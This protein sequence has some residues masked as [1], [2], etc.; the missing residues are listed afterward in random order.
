MLFLKSFWFASNILFSCIHI[1]LSRR[2]HRKNYRLV[3]RSSQHICE[4]TYLYTLWQR[5][6]SISHVLHREVQEVVKAA[7]T[8]QLWSFG[9]SCVLNHI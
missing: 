1:L 7:F 9:I 3:V 5:K 4:P 8:Y 2:R 6:G